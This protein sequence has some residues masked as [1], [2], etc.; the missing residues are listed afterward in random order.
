MFPLL[1]DPVTRVDAFIGELLVTLQQR[2]E[3]DLAERS[4]AKRAVLDEIE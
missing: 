1:V 3:R 2:V 4:E